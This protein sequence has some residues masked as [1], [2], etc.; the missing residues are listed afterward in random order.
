MNQR[1]QQAVGNIS[2][3]LYRGAT[4]YMRRDNPLYG[5]FGGLGVVLHAIEELEADAAAPLRELDADQRQRNRAAIEARYGR[6]QV[7]AAI[8]ALDGFRRQPTGR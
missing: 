1:R 8:R 5:F 2:A 7:V 3:A 6:A 4:V